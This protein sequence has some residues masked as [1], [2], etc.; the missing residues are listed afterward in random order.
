M[1]ELSTGDTQRLELSSSDY[2]AGQEPIQLSD[3]EWRLFKLECKY[4]I[5]AFLLELNFRYASA[6]RQLRTAV[7]QVVR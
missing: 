3:I 7:R 5:K 2:P 4:A 1:Y 6:I